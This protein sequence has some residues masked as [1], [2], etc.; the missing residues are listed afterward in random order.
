M[1]FTFYH[2]SQIQYNN[3]FCRLLYT[4]VSPHDNAVAT[5]TFSDLFLWP[6]YTYKS[7]NSDFT[8]LTCCR[9]LSSK[10]RK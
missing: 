8:F 4:P 10:K 3:V 6:P 7:P 9:G 1:T 2:S 5:Y